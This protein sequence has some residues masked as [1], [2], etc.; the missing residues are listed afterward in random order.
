[1]RCDL[2]K[3]RPSDDAI[4]VVASLC[5][6]Q[7]PKALDGIRDIGPQWVLESIGD[8]ALVVDER[9]PGMRQDD[10]RAGVEGVD[11]PLEQVRGVEVVVGHPL[12]E[13]AAGLRDHE[14]VIER[15]AAV[16]PVVDVSHPGV[17]GLVLPGDGGS[18]VGGAVIRDDQL[19]VG[20][21]LRQKSVQRRSKETL[22]VVDRQTQREPGR[23]SSRCHVTAPAAE[24]W[25]ASAEQS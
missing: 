6:Q 12:E 5:V 9:R 22:A 11:A 18:T 15:C 10:L 19:E 14:V 20:K 2:T 13:L 25:S 24:L 3:D 21:G 8:R 4:D 16:S 23:P 17:D 1:M 7:A